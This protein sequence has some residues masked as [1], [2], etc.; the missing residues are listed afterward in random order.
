MSLLHDYLWQIV[1]AAIIVA[2]AIIAFVISRRPRKLNTEHYHKKWRDVQ[3]LCKEQ[4]TWPLA[5]INADR[6]LDE[7]L[8]SRRTRGNTTGERLV[9]AQKKF[10][11]NDKL[12]HAHK[13]R[14]RLVH[15]SD[16]PLKERDVKRALMGVR[17]GLKDLGALE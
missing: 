13:L 11:D 2:I 17:Q 6:L 8:K 5:V 14:N 15:E 4:Q 3:K 7:A 12:W 16:V 10:S 9:S 1:L